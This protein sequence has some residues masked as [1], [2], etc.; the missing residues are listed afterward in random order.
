V[1]N[2]HS[3]HLVSKLPQKPQALDPAE[4]AAEVLR[5]VR[6]CS[7]ALSDFQDYQEH[8]TRQ[9]SAHLSS[10]EMVALRAMAKK[11]RKS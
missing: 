3:I 6:E 5:T 2:A 9:M 7:Q 1:A 11:A 4:I 10:L 8:L